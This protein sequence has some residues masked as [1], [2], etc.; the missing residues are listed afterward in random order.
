MY[1]SLYRKT[2]KISNRTNSKQ[3]HEITTLPLYEPL[4][5]QDF[6]IKD[7]SPRI[8]NDQEEYVFDADQ[9][10]STLLR[11]SCPSCSGTGH[12][13]HLAAHVTKTE[14]QLVENALDAYRRGY[15]YIKDNSVQDLAAEAKEDIDKKAAVVFPNNLLLQSWFTTGAITAT[16][17]LFGKS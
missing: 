6:I 15:S 10:A 11:T 14:E 17:V 12:A 7:A 16:T 9:V 3:K 8:S 13:T 5:R 2:R 4:K 1:S